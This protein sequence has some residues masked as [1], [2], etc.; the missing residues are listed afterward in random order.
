MSDKL[1]DVLLWPIYT[2]VS[3]L[4]KGMFGEADT[5]L[6]QA[7]EGCAIGMVSIAIAMVVYPTLILSLVALAVW[8]FTQ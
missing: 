8:F 4:M 1:L 3:W 6:A 2:P 5:N 7:N